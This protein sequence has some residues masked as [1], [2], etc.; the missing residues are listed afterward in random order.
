MPFCVL[1]WEVFQIK[2]LGL[3]ISFGRLL[4]KSYLCSKNFTLGLMVGRINLVKVVLLR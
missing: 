1:N 2:Y 3:S 4:V